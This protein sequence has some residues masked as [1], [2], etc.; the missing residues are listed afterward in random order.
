MKPYI[1]ARNGDKQ[2]IRRAPET[3]ISKEHTRQLVEDARQGDKDAFGELYRNHFGAIYRLARFYLGPDAAED[4]A[5]E[6][7]LR[8]WNGLPRY[9]WTGAP[10]VSWLY[11]IARNVVFDQLRVRKR[12]EPR[13]DVPDVPHDHLPQTL[14][15][16]DVA[17]AIARLPDEQ[18]QVIE[19]KF[20]IG[21]PNAE[22][23]EILGK[24]IGAVNAQQWRA[25]GNLRRIL[26]EGSG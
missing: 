20:L 16:L 7:F 21:L 25:L 3:V 6:T 17:D 12:T 22:V 26:E 4:A 5:A 23:A 15:R 11:G 2:G 10:F 1:T 18:R 13:A 8:A 19:M 9:R 24:T 14:I